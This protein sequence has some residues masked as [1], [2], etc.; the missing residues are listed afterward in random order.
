MIIKVCEIC[1]KEYDAIIIGG[2]GH[3]L[4]TAYYLAKNHGV[5]NIA[6]VEKHQPVLGVI[7]VPTLS[8]LYFAQQNNGSL[9]LFI[10]NNLRN[11]CLMHFSSCTQNENSK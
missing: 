9:K 10:N 1:K 5:T 2:G 11:G 6:L 7:Y 8:T 4:T 3:G